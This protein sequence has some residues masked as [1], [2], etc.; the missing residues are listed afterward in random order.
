MNNTVKTITGVAVAAAAGAIAGVAFAPDKG[1]KTR[2]K[3]SKKIKAAS[4]DVSDFV[5]TKA[6]QLKSEASNLL[7][8]GKSLVD[9]AINTVKA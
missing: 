2:A 4:S 5:S 1:S 8:Q 9:N 6:N 7:N 3:A